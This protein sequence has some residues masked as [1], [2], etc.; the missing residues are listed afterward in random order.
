MRAEKGMMSVLAVQ[1]DGRSVEVGLIGREGFVG[2]PLVVGYQ[3]TTRPTDV[4]LRTFASLYVN[5]LSWQR[6]KVMKSSSAIKRGFRVDE[7]KVPELWPS[8]TGQ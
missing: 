5:V 6:L 3:L 7:A 2:L 4:P 1:P 8:A